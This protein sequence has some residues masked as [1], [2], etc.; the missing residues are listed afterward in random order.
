[1]LAMF[2]GVFAVGLFGGGR[3][4]VLC[5]ITGHTWTDMSDPPACSQCGRTRLIYYKALTIGE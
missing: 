5:R 4:S 2:R 3:R 1:M